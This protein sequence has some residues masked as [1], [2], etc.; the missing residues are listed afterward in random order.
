MFTQEQIASFKKKLEATKRDLET[1][2]KS[3]A[4]NPE[5]GSDVDHFE[6][7]ADE[8]EEYSK[9]LGVAKAMKERLMNVAR[10]LEKI[11]NGTYGTCEK[12][13]GAIE[14][15]ILTVDPESGHCKKCKKKIS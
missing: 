12:C 11:S 13:G 14:S 6:E 10:A 8:A 9:N 3:L 5:F 15:A 4:K 2:L 1:E 7:E